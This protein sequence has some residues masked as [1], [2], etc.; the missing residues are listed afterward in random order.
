VTVT[1]LKPDGS[2]LTSNQWFTS[3]FDLS[4]QTLPAT[5][6]YSIK[7]DPSTTDTGSITVNVSTP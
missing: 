4:Q 6:T 3:S 5:G 7:V 1:L 2:Q